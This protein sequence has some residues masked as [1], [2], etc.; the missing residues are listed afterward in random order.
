M[1]LILMMVTKNEADR[2]LDSV[3]LWNHQYASVACVYDDVSEDETTAI[4]A[5]HNC[6]VQVRPP[7]ISSFLMHE[8]EFRQAAWDWM[9]ET[10][11]PQEGDWI[12]SLD[13]DEFLVHE[14]GVS[15]LYHEIEQAE[16]VGATG[17][18]C[19]VP[20]IFDGYGGTLYRRV[21]GYW[22]SIQALRLVKWYP[23]GRFLNRKM[24]CG[25]VPHCEKVTWAEDMSIL[26]V[27]Y[28]NNEDAR[29]KYNRYKNLPGHNPSHVRSIL[30][31]GTLEAWDGP[32]PFS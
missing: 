1:R 6:L 19:Q 5:V 12:L 14:Q 31:P 10:V 17:I 16:K 8:G 28:I 18:A 13:A 20:E 23:G 2:Y 4:A 25:S 22:G 29:A 3:L 26:H 7:Y 11:K 32:I 21:D 27:G 24:A 15:G 30:E 9:E